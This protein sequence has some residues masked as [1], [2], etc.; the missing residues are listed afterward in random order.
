MTEK[1]EVAPYP[2]PAY[3][4]FV[5]AVLVFAALIAF[6]DRQVVAI[7]VDPMKEDLGVGD[8]QIGWLYGVFAVFY[9][10]AAIPI[11]WL[12][13]RKSR[14]HIIAAGIFLW[15]LMTMACG[16]SRSFWYVFAARIGV[17]VGEATLTPATTSMVGDYFPRDQIPLALSVFQTGAIMGSGIAFIIGGFVLNIVEQADPLVLPLV[18][19]LRPWQQT[20]VYVGAPGI[21]LAI[22]LLFLREP[23]R[24]SASGLGQ[25]E[26]ATVG[27]ILSF[28]RRHALTL[29]FHHIGFLSFAL[30]G[31]AFVFWTVSFFVRVHGY[32][33]ADASQIFGWIFFVTGPMGPVIVALFA[34]WLS[35][36]GRGDA[37]ILAGMVGGMLAIPT[38]I[39]I[40]FVPSATLAI[41]L[42]VPAMIFIN[43]PFGI[44][45]G[46]LP[47]ITPPNMRAQVAA[48]YML[49]VSVGMMLGPPLAGIFNEQ[50]FP[51]TDGVRYSLIT[52]TSIFGLLGGASLWL[53]R[54]HYAASLAHA[55]ET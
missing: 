35:N 13:D 36:R 31:Y 3:S 54:R 29:M 42:Y 33:A 26:Q 51:G 48:V 24:R 16:L 52:L 53:G 7:V 34:R 14:K 55:D 19:E 9:A 6:I 18:G 21:L 45:A 5:V 4:W 11:A 12:A 38:I 40:Q 1:A 23:V 20:F 50:I 49:M 25:P 22:A 46:S 41:V 30:M 47:V 28:Y 37:N 44:A 32:Q 10:V 8:A 39:L 43:S 15:S 2:R 17:G 27:E